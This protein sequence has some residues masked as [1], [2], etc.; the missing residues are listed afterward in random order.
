MKAKTIFTLILA[1]V[2][3]AGISSCEDM[4]K[5]DS[6]TYDY[7]HEMTAQDTVYSV[8]GIIQK[9]QEI[10]DR[11][12]L[13]GEIRGDL[14]T[15]TGNQTPEITELYNYDFANLS[16]D[17]K[18]NRP[19]DYYAVINNCNYFL[20]NV[21][22]SLYANGE[23]V[24]L[25]EYI[26]VLCF[27][28]WTYLQMAQIYGRV[29]YV[30]KPITSG[31]EATSGNFRLMDIKTL[32]KELLVEFEKNA[33]KYPDYP[34][35]NY[36]SL[37]GSDNDEGSKS[38]KH[39]SKDLLIP[40]RL[41]MGDLYLWSEQFEKAAK[42]YHDYLYYNNQATILNTVST[43]TGM[44]L[45][46]GTTFAKLGEDTY[47]SNFGTNAKPI[48][49]IPMA[50]EEYAGVTSNLP[51]IFNSTLDN[52][53]YPQL[54]W[55][56]AMASLSQRQVYC[57]HNIRPLTGVSVAEYMSDPEGMQTNPLLRGDLRLQS[58]FE[59]KAAKAEDIKSLLDNTSRQTLKKINSEKISLYR[60]DVVYLRLA[61]ALNRAGLPNMA[62]A[63][64]KNGL[65][66]DF[67]L[68]G[69]NL[70]EQDKATALGIEFPRNYFDTVRYQ[71][72][73]DQININ[74]DPNNPSA[75]DYVRPVSNNNN[76]RGVNMGI[77]SRGSGDA[78]MNKYFKI[79]LDPSE[80]VGISFIDT[81]RRVEEMILDEMALETCFEGYR[82]GDLMRIS[83]HRA[84]DKG[85]YDPAK[86][87]LSQEQIKF[88]K[89]FFA[90][91]VASRD[92]A[93][94]ANPFAG[95]DSDLYNTLKGEDGDEDLFPQNWFL[96]LNT[97]IY[98]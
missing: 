80:S 70:T 44:I 73:T 95:R 84:Y 68:E 19:I 57:Y 51:D 36:G 72:V 59:V 62:F 78:A 47:A 23:N 30:D 10:A 56:K 14:V 25:K 2:F 94:P 7:G 43:G 28:A 77:H 4:L 29:Y 5:V 81:I 65:A 15:V 93:T 82:F 20:A 1:V 34:L 97:S 69:I 79:T 64:L 91:R 87:D 3:T 42:Y 39:N 31:D 75:A 26:P 46:N 8:M 22:T 58:I 85:E 53:Y 49:Y 67:I 83:M 66:E 12:V 61:E 74:N 18:Y 63:V 33:N 45:W 92:D 89:A 13:L 32:A 90:D 50:S 52:H 21:D 71:I 98:Y 17:N 96:R 86:P 24:F 9:M 40:V 37:G 48:T 6:K 16:A 88:D 35:L 41:I 60:N 11:S 38:Q 55:S 54:T 27:R 76:T